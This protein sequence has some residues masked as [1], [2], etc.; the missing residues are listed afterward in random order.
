MMGWPIRTPTQELATLLE[1]DSSVRKEF[2]RH[3]QLRT[4]VQ[5]LCRAQKACDG[6]LARVRATLLE[7]PPSDTPALGILPATFHSS[8][9]YFSSGWPVAYLV[10]TV[11]FAIGLVVGAIV[12]V[13]TPQV[14]LPSPSGGRH[15]EAGEKGQGRGDSLSASIVGRITGMVDCRWSEPDTETINGAHVAL[16]RRYALS[17]G[18]LEVTYDTGAKVLLQGPVTYEVESPTG[19]FLSI[20]KLTAKLEKK[21]ASGQWSVVSGQ[22][23]SS[24]QPLATSHS[25]NPQSLIPNPLFSVRTPTAV[26]TD[27]G[28]EF[29]VEVDKHGATISHVFRGRVKLEVASTR[30]SPDS[31]SRMLQANESA[32]VEEAASKSHYTIR[33]V[34]VDPKTF[35]Q[36]ERLRDETRGAK[37]KPF[38]RWQAYFNDFRRDPSLL[39]CY[40]FQQRK[41]AAFGSHQCG[42]RRRCVAEWRCQERRLDRRPHAEQ[43]RTPV[44][45]GK[46]PCR[47]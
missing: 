22:K 16:G 8:A 5:L 15:E 12:H 32:K 13:S 6:G 42:R 17:S 2:V 44:P 35:V 4:D 19:G 37:L 34:V 31:P 23:S 29:G 21:V 20:G 26:V 30:G 38:R 28:T 40:D 18:L 41:R 46:R 14:V 9:G 39:A 7:M 45:G 47:C 43:T 33:T 3:V 36:I 24:H 25:S 27:L 1:A 10:A 11:I